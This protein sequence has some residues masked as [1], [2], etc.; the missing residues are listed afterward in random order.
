[1]II[2]ADDLSGAQECAAAAMDLTPGELNAATL[3]AATMLFNQAIDLPEV[4]I[5]AVDVN[6]RG[7]VR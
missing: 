6:S 3:S 2:L 1:M 5:C 4:D 7:C